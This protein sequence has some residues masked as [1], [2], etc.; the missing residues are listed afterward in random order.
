MASS[1]IVAALFLVLGLVVGLAVV[2]TTLPAHVVTTTELSSTTQVSTQNETVTRSTTQVLTQTLT[3]SVTQYVPT[4]TTQVVT[5]SVTS[6]MTL[7]AVIT[8]IGSS[9]QTTTQTVTQTSSAATTQNFTEVGPGSLAVLS[10]T[11]NSTSQ[12]F[13]PTSP[14]VRVSLNVTATVNA[15]SV[16]LTWY[17]FQVGSSQPA[18]TGK[19][20]GSQ[21]PF[22]TLCS[23]TPSGVQAGGTYYIEVISKDAS[24]QLSVVAV[25]G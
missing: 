22:S 9:T 2:G 24:W 4:V 16:A 19:V 3:S 11:V 1:I 12:P 20:S 18:C 8:V 23:G 6:T 10:G 15:S 14:E 13:T 5:T 17:I 21:G 7:P 25:F